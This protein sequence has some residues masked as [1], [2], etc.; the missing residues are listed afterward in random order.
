MTLTD[1]ANHIEEIR[2]LK[3]ELDALAE[4]NDELM[5]ELQHAQDDRDALAATL[6]L[7][8]KAMN[9]TA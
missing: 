2:A 6:R 4:K 9:G 1:I 8:R 5:R 3:S 7:I